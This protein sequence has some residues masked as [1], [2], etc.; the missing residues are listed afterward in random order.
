NQLVKEQ[1]EAIGLSVRLD[2][3]AQSEWYARVV[4]RKI[5]FTPMRWTQR[6]DPDGLLYILF[7]SKGYANS[8]GYSNPEVDRLLDEARSIPDMAERKA[9]YDQV[10]ALL[11]EDLPYVPVGFAAEYVAMNKGVHG[12]RWI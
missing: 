9:L 7:H 1:V 2:P 8:T 4:D 3:V 12:F 6:A 5:N 10:H 11:L